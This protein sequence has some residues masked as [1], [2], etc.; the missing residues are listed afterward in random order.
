MIAYY[1]IVGGAKRYPLVVQEI[2][3]GRTLAGLPGRSEY[4]GEY[5]VFSPCGRYIANSDRNYND[6]LD[7]IMSLVRV[8]DVTASRERHVLKSSP[9]RESSFCFSSDSRYLALARNQ[10]EIRLWDMSRRRMT[11]A[12]IDW[13]DSGYPHEVAFS[14]DGKLIASGGSDYF[15]REAVRERTPIYYG[16]GGGS[17]KLSDAATGALSWSESISSQHP[18]FRD[19]KWCAGWVSA[20]AFSPDGTLLAVGLG[21]WPSSRVTL[22]KVDVKEKAEE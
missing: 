2:D 9:S 18:A 8:A 22:W 21:S 10:D 3:S 11:S 17:V 5:L 13:R 20:L 12:S 1:E 15:I 4:G 16:A 6:R 14:P 19:D 7:R